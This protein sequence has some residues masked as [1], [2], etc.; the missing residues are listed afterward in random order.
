[1]AVRLLLHVTISS[2]LLTRKTSIIYRANIIMIHMY[3][4][5]IKIY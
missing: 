2:V 1:L 5:S 4:A 3:M